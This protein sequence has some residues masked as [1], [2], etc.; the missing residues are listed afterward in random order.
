VQDSVDIS[1]KEQTTDKTL[2]NIVSKKF[3]NGIKI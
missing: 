2:Q 1:V 3:E